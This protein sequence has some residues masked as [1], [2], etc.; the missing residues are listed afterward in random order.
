MSH[1]ALWGRMQGNITRLDICLAEPDRKQKYRTHYN[2]IEASSGKGRSGKPFRRKRNSMKGARLAELDSALNMD[3]RMCRLPER[4]FDGG[5]RAEPSRLMGSPRAGAA[6]KKM[7]QAAEPSSQQA[8]RGG[9]AVTEKRD[10][11]LILGIPS[12]KERIR[13]KMENLAFRT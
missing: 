1:R 3:E 12:D 8:S 4:F 7:E 10:E 11:I 6:E 5:S 9:G 2:F 13:M